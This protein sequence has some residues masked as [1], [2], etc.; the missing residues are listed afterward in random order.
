MKKA[1]LVLLVVFLVSSLSVVTSEAQRPQPARHRGTDDRRRDDTDVRHAVL[2]WR[3]GDRVGPVGHAAVAGRDV[4][5]DRDDSTYRERPLLR[6]HGG[7][8]GA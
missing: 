6:C 3:V 4:H 8:R 1:V 2:C 5:R 7:T